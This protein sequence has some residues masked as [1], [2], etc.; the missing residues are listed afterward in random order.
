MFEVDFF[1][2]GDR[3]TSLI[4]DIR[5]AFANKHYEHTDDGKTRIGGDVNFTI[6]GVFT[7]WVNRHEWVQRAIDEKDPEKVRRMRALVG[8]LGLHDGF[9]QDQLGCDHNIIPAKGINGILDLV[10][11][12]KTKITTWY[13]G[14]FTSDSTPATGWES[15]W[16]G[17]TTPD[18]DE[19][20]GASF[21]GTSRRA[22]T[23]GTAAASKSISTSSASSWTLTADGEG[24][25]IY[26]STLNEV[27]TI[28]YALTTKILVAATAFTTPKRGL[29]QNDVLNISYSI[30]GAST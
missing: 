28:A 8:R 16:A 10:F 17:K 25:D 22:A 30:T 2:G 27:S 3:L 1:K 12:D 7:S 4:R 11:G 21:G 19:L 15:D 6:G 24:T 14:P 20:P 26:G 18:A 13:Q 29:G 23:F 9:F 5:R